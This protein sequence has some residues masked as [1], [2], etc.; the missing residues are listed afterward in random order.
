MHTS[1]TKSVSFLSIL[2]SVEIKRA[3]SETLMKE[4]ANVSCSMESLHS[5]KTSEL[6]KPGSNEHDEASRQCDDLR[7]ELA[8]LQSAT[9]SAHSDNARLQVHVAT[10]QSRITAL[11]A[12]HTALQVANTQLVAEKDEVRSNFKF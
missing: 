2:A 6:V 3:V 5:E 9:E 12:Q 8:T 1:I 7:S 10:L 4:T 11:S